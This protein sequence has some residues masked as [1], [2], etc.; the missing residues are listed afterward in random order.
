MSKTLDVQIGQVKIARRGETLK[1]ILGSCVGIAFIWEARNKCGLAHC[2][3]PQQ[4]KITYEIGARYVD[5]A[6]RS[7][8]AMLKITASDTKNV[9]AVVVGGGNMTGG[10]R[11]ESKLVGANNFRTAIAEVENR[12][13]DLIHSDGGGNL[14]RKII[15]YGEEFS[16]NVE[17]IPRISN[18][19]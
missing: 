11:N 10:N 16:F 15:V 12:G 3:L 5:Q 4:P 17:S 13:F 8:M 18:M 2:L 6:V 1:A 19:N 14:G 7:L 9:K